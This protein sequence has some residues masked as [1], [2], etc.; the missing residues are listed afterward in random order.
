MKKDQN[1]LLESDY[2]L[3]IEEMEPIEYQ[4]FIEP[5]LLYDQN[6]YNYSINKSFIDNEIIY[7][8]I[9]KELNLT[10]IEGFVSILLK[11]KKDNINTIILNIFKIQIKRVYIINEV[12]KNNKNIFIKIF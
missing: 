1:N 10:Q 5:K 6:S 12:I 4:I 9:K 3:S 8:I 2:L 11:I 7:K